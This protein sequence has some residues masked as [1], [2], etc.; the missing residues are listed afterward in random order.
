LITAREKLTDVPK[1]WRQGAGAVENGLLIG[2]SRQA[3]LERQLDVVANNI[4]N[5][6]TTGFKSTN[7]IFQE[8]LSEGARDRT[9]SVADAPIHF[10]FDREAWHDFSQ[11]PIVQTGNPLDIALDGQG[12]IA[13]QTQ[14]GERY[15]RNGALKINA[16]GQLV[17][18]DGATVE[19]DNGPITFQATDR[20]I[21][22]GADGR[23]AVVEGPNGSVETLRGRIKLVNFANPQQL[24]AE[25][26]STFSAPAGV[27]PQAATNLRVIQGAVEGSNVNAVAEMTRMIEINRTYSMIASLLQSRDD[28]RR[29]SID[30]LAAVPN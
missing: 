21:T 11:G 22:V 20:K 10:V 17:T 25:G 14:G 5:A 29:N 19:G 16:T 28:E 1:A 8:F 7:S 26:A 9:F 2:L 27:A 12:F 4:A 24:T 30:K 23:I 15:T 18:T 13:V 3:T 6:N